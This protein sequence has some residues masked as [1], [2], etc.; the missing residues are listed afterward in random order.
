M[1]GASAR[2]RSTVG[3]LAFG[4]LACSV[5][6]PTLVGLLA[7]DLSADLGFGDRGLG[8]AVSGFWLVSAVAAPLCG[9]WIDRRGWLPGALCGAVVVAGCLLG[10]VLWVRSWPGL[11][12]V[13]AAAGVGYALC[14]PTSNLLVVSLVGRGRQASVL[15]FKQTAPPVMSALAG[16]T[17]PALAHA[18]G[19][20]PAVLAA[21]AV[22][23]AVVAGSW[24]LSRDRLDRD[25]VLLGPV[26]AEGAEPRPLRPVPVVVAAG[27]G[28]LSVATVTGFAV[29]TLVGAGVPPVVAAAVV[30]GGSVLAILAR[31]FGGAFLDA[32]PAG[33][34]GPLLWL[35]GVAAAGLAVTAVG[36]T[37]VG[38]SSG[39][40]WTGAVVLGVVVSLVAAWTW[41][42]LLLLAVVRRARGAGA[43]SGLLQ[44]G[45]GVGAAI[46][47]LGFGLLSEAGG[48]GWA[49]CV[50]AASTAAAMVLVRAAWADAGSVD[51][52]GTPGGRSPSV[53]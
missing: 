53:V 1:T 45:S 27:L 4:L 47:P 28:T 15:G 10:C 8:V 11:L 36:V 14:S 52:L 26:V 18:H 32:R 41:P 29:L 30:S 35:M 50:M 31:V 22:P 3:L 24:G 7:V 49:W 25:G 34:L 12:L 6:L 48:R 16:L 33:D 2:S 21:T 46:G 20:R 23:L 9:R 43:A 39:P 38:R 37:G 42:A 17:L 19:W 40:G 51:G 44:L 5:V 13:L